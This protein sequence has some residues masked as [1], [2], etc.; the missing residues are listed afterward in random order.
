MMSLTIYICIENEDEE[1][2]SKVHYL[3][4]NINI[5]KNT[6]HTPTFLYTK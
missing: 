1:K 2:H 6:V 5:Y 3:Y 4:A